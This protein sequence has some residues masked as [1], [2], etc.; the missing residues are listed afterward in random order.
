M[1]V[2]EPDPR[3]SLESYLQAIEQIPLL[4]RDEERLLAD[5]AFTGGES[6]AVERL[7]RSKL[8]LV[9]RICRSYR[10]RGLPLEDLVNE[11]N[12]GLLEATR[13][14]DPQRGQ[15]FLAFAVLCIRRAILR[16]L[17]RQQPH[18]AAAPQRSIEENGIA[19]LPVHPSDEERSG[20]DAPPPE[21]SLPPDRS[22]CPEVR[23]LRAETLALI[24][25]SVQ[26]LDEPDRYVLMR[27]FG[28]QDGEPASLKVIADRLGVTPEMV[29]LI[30]SRA[31]RRVRTIIADWLFPGQPPM[32]SAGQLRRRTPIDQPEQVAAQRLNRP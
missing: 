24:R 22:D 28:L 16:A 15:R 6:D 4:S 8:R 32:I 26:R 21:E 29:R 11:G 9:V 3:S 17:E 31:R 23:F 30:E 18:V 27:R 20:E 10:D 5:R 7:V 19:A 1:N 25:R 2:E 14:F 12:L 13:R